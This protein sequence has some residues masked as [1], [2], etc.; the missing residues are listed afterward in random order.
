M[1][2]PA[3]GSTRTTAAPAP[4]SREAGRGR[5]RRPSGEPPPLPHHLQ[6]SGIRWLVAMLVLLVLT[7]LVFGRGLRGLAV[8]MSVADA[9]VVGWLAGIDLPGFEAAMRGLAALSSWWVLNAVSYGLIVAL[10]VLRRF[11][12]GCG[13][14]GWPTVTSSRPT[15]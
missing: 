12:H 5:R 14:P 11:R 4:G 2:V 13:T 9:A 1:D 3:D 10:L 6:T 8:D 15:C 7:I